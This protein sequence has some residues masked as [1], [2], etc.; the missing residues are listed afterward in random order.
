[1]YIYIYSATSVPLF[2][3]PYKMRFVW[4]QTFST[5]RIMYPKVKWLFFTFSG[6]FITFNGLLIT[7]D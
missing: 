1:M 3:N 5:S 4:S 6:F 7:L 2:V